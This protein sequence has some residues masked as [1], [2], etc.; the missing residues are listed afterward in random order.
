MNTLL[1]I[2]PSLLIALTVHECAHALVAYW[3]GDDTAKRAGRLT[4]NPLKHLDPL[5]TLLMVVAHIG[6]GKPVPVNPYNLRSP[7]YHQ[8]L[9]A[10]AG[11]FSNILLALLGFILLKHVTFP[12]SVDIFLLTFSYLN[13][14]LAAFNLLPFPPLDGGN[15][16]HLFPHYSGSRAEYAVLHYAPPVLLSIFLFEMVFH[17]SLLMPLIRLISDPLLHFLYYFA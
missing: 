5:G 16:L 8:V 10:L 14:F 6:W 9:V 13:V 11:P 17:V 4:L 1:Y 15:L 12:E 2:L 3:C 7:R